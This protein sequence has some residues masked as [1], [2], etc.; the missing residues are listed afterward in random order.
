[1]SEKRKQEILQM[2]EDF[3]ERQREQGIDISPTWNAIKQNL[4]YGNY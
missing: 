3:E 2:M 4:A 1:M